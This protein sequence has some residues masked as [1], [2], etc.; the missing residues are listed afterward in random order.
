MGNGRL[1]IIKYFLMVAVLDE[2]RFLSFCLFGYVKYLA[3][4]L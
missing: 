1:L 4:C 3:S 2:W